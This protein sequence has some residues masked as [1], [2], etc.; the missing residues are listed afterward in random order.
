MTRLWRARRLMWAIA[1]LG[2]GSST[3]SA[4]TPTFKLQ[5]TQPEAVAVVQQF[6][7]TLKVDTAVAVAL[8]PT[9]V[10]QGTGSLCAAPLAA[11][12]SGSHTLVVTAFNGF[13]SAATTLAGAP[14][15]APAGMTITVTISFP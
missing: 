2:I 4:Q 15:T 6:Q 3:A 9:C 11:M 8:T 12:A 1:L 7:Y 13:G 14:P 10:T 5:W